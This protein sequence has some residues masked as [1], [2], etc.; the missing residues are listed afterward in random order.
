M[1][2]FGLDLSY[3]PKDKEQKTKPEATQSS[4]PQALLIIDRDF[5]LTLA[6]I[7][8]LAGTFAALR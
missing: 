5:L 6:I 1:N 8:V 3:A 7:V 2:L 4:A